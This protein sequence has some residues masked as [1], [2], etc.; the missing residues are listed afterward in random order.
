M[1]QRVISGALVG[2]ISLASIYFG[3]YLLYAVLAFIAL[4]GS[5]EVILIRNKESN[6][7]L[8]LAMILFIAA[9]VF[10]P[11]AWMS[12]IIMLYI[13]SLFYLAMAIEDVS[14][15]D[16]SCTLLLTLIIAFAINGALK[17]HAISKW[18]LVYLLATSFM[19]DTGAFFVGRKFGKRKLIERVSP[20]K[21]VEG[22][23]GGWLT[24]AILSFLLAWLCKF[25]G[26]EVWFIAVCSIVLP[27]VS[28]LGDLSFSFVKRNYGVKDFSNLIPG[29]GGLLDRID[30]LLLCIL[31]FSAVVSF[32]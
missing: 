20:N 5:Y 29:H 18:I 28:E 10:L 21:T 13:I 1:K 22:A 30:S 19:S 24:G 12:G 17:L 26:F 11:R 23:I 6:K 2:I 7:A 25:F 8:Y 27:L 15:S 16:I 3:G 14:L 9:A 32:L 31:F 4:Y